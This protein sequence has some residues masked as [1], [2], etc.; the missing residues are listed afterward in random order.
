MSFL[1]FKYSYDGQSGR[2]SVHGCTRLT[3]FW[4][5]SKWNL[6]YV[7]HFP[8]RESAKEWAE[9]L[10]KNH[11]RPQSEML[12]YSSSGVEIFGAGC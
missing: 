2:A 10:I 8:T 5:G 11:A 3:G 7:E 4:R 1:R 9:K 12:I 6:L